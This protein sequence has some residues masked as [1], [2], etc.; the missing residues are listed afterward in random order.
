MD[1]G[2]AKYFRLRT[3]DQVS[4]CFTSLLPLALYYSIKLRWLWFVCL[5]GNESMEDWSLVSVWTKLISSIWED[6]SLKMKHYFY[7]GRRCQKQLPSVLRT[8][9]LWGRS[10][11]LL[12]TLVE[13]IIH[14]LL[15]HHAYTK[16]YILAQLF[17]KNTIHDI[18]VAGFHFQYL[19]RGAPHNVSHGKPCLPTMVPSH[20][21]KFLMLIFFPFPDPETVLYLVHH[22]HHHVPHEM[23]SQM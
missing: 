13:H 6:V 23:W 10:F 19:L 7:R 12:F 4:W 18:K 22:L 3:Q 8:S 5:F 11:S 9:C 20:S 1:A 15:T 14:H 2:Y 17:L 21:W 16:H